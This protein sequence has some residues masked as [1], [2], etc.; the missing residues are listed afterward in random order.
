MD[1]SKKQKVNAKSTTESE[2]IGVD[3]AM[4]KMIWADLFI[5]AQGYTPRST[6]LHQDNTSSIALE[7]NGR[8]SAGQRTR[9][10]NIRYF[11]IKDQVDQGWVRIRYCPTEEMVADHYTKP[12][13]G[14]IFR[15]M[16]ALIM[17]CDI[18]ISMAP[19][20][21][22]EIATPVMPVKRKSKVQFARL[23]RPSSRA[24]ECV[25]QRSV[26]AEKPV[27]QKLGTNNSRSL[28]KARL[29]PIARPRYNPQVLSPQ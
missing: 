22:K 4:P 9:H 24:Q 27:K 6:I 8:R 5:R 13:Q 10:I 21:S 12:L 17:N 20:K 29:A 19:W 25:G 3:D 16:R 2:L 7:V 11:F 18:N 1:M 23:S 26:L 14:M 15:K 28:A